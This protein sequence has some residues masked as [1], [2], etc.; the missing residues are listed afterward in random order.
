M[1]AATVVIVPVL[2]LF[3]FALRYFIEGPPDRLTGIKA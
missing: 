3:L 1:A 2:F